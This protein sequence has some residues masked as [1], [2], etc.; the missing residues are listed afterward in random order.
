MSLL[1]TR[2]NFSFELIAVD[3][4]VNK[5]VSHCFLMQIMQIVN[6]VGI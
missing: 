6:I 2:I 1:A 5:V 4:H 3:V